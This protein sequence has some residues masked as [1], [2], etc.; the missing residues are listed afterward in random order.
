M[1]RPVER[2]SLRSVAARL[3]RSTN[4][5]HWAVKSGLVDPSDMERSAAAWNRAY[6]A[7]K[8][9]AP[10]TATGEAR[11]R[12]EL[13]KAEEKEIKVRVLKGELIDRARTTRMHFEIA[14]AV[15]ETLEQ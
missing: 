13:A 12:L 14:K 10:T 5:L 8:Q 1:A 4:S 15:R 3:G 9:P 2:N 11:R 7:V 6:P